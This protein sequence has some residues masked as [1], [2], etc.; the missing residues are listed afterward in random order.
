[1]CGVCC[2]DVVVLS[3][4]VVCVA[5][6]G[7]RNPPPSPLPCVGSNVSVCTLQTLPCVPASRLFF[8]LSSVVLFLRSLSLLFL[9]SS[10]SVTMTM[11]T[12]PVG[13]LCVRTSSGLALRARVHGPWPIPCWPNMFASCT[14]QLSWYNCASL[15]PL[16]MKW[17]CI[18]AGNG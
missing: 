14:K 3:C 15:V 7:T 17:A 9:F 16:G 4:C 10:L 18:C 1:M 11:I 12:P 5:R 13:S 2:V 6:H 8:F